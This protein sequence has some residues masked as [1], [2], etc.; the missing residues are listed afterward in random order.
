MPRCHMTEKRNK[1]DTVR[2]ERLRAGMTSAEIEALR[3]RSE[4]DPSSLTLDEVGVL[5]LETRARIRT[6]EAKARKKRGRG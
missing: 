1:W 3:A 4:S 5:F 6:I 2:L